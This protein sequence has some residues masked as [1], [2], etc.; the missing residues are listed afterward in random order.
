[1][2][3]EDFVV[4]ENEFQ[5]SCATVLLLDMSGSMARYG[6]FYHAKHVA[7]ALQGLVRSRYTE[8]SLKIIGFYTYASPLTEREVVRAAPKPVSIFDSRVF[9]RISLDS[10]PKFVPEHFTNIQ[11]GLKFARQHLARQP[12]VNKQIICVTDG[13][14]TAHLEGRELV[15]AYPPNER[16]ARATLQEVHACTQAGIKISTFALIEDYYYLGLVN[17]VDQMARLSQGLAV[18]CTAGQLGG[19]V[20]DSFVKGRRN[21]KTVGR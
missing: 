18:Y 13:E 11:A 17:F 14:P 19:Y 5:T 8:D 2:E 6:K 16:T 20:L 7:L 10:P 12:G 1:V 21:R 15:L 9:L 3:E 4:Y